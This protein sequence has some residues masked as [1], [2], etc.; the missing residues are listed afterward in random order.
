[1]TVTE[2]TVFPL[3]HPRQLLAHA[4]VVIDDCFVIHN[5][6]II[7][8]LKRVFLALP[9]EA[10]RFTCGSC[11]RRVA[12]D[13]YCGHCGCPLPTPDGGWD[14]HARWRDVIHP[15]TAECRAYLEE[16]V[17]SAYHKAVGI[18]QPTRTEA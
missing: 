9:E 10:V 3:D 12:Y 14:N 7:N 2:V 11:H 18:P 1:V 8:G 16:T 5:C 15:I 6:R 17:L 13:R 4:A